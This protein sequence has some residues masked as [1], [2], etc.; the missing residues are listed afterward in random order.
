MGAVEVMLLDGEST[1]G[2]VALA[3]VRDAW[4]ATTQTQFRMYAGDP[5]VSAVTLAEHKTGA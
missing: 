1:P 2:I 5:N 3:E 4:A